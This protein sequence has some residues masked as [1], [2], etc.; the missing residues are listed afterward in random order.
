[1]FSPNPGCLIAACPVFGVP[2][3]VFPPPENRY[4]LTVLRGAGK[5]ALDLQPA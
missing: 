1:M 5:V 2:Y 3:P 4:A